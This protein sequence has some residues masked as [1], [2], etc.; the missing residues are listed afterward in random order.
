MPLIEELPLTNPRAA[1]PGWAYV[2]DS[3]SSQHILPSQS[4]ASKR[5]RATVTR[6]VDTHYAAAAGHNA[7]NNAAN[8]IGG[9][10]ASAFPAQRITAKQQK[11]I[12][13]RLKDLGRENYKD[14]V[15]I[16]VPKV[17]GSLLKSS[18]AGGAAAAAAAGAGGKKTSSNVKRI[19]GYNRNF[20]HYLADEEAAIAAGGGGFQGTWGSGVAITAGP[21]APTMAV[22]AADRRK[23]G[24]AATAKVKTEKKKKD[25]GGDVTM[26]DAPSSQMPTKDAAPSSNP[27]TASAQQH[28]PKPRYDPALDKDPLLKTRNQLP[29]P[30]DRVIAALL[31]EPPLS[32]TV[33]RARAMPLEQQRPRRWFCAMCGYW[34]KVKCRR[35]GERCCGLLECWRGHE[36][37]GCVPY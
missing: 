32:Y 9:G 10:F 11:A 16:A 15:A 4:L 34:G 31:A 29:K 8:A 25:D 3:S 30:S 37:G 2:P 17:E 22:G 1:Q 21:Q 36:A 5:K 24:V 27:N 33:A 14:G 23:S 20:G 12:D 18:G 13:Q 19:L 28:P 26:E 35:C 7:A 6:L